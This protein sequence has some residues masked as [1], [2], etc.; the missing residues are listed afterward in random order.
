[1]PFGDHFRQR[2][3][4]AMTQLL[5]RVHAKALKHLSVLGPDTFELMEVVLQTE[6]R[7][8]VGFEGV[9]GAL[10]AALDGDVITSIHGCGE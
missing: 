1:M 3:R 4:V 2:C 7:G 5:D 9:L 8:V 6:P 10:L